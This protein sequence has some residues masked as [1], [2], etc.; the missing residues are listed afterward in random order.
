MFT[1]LARLVIYVE[2]KKVRRKERQAD[3]SE[4]RQENR[5]F[6]ICWR[7]NCFNLQ[8]L[9]REQSENK[10]LILPCLRNYGELFAN[11]TLQKKCTVMKI[12]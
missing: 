12:I 11:N 1:V 7:E 2:R 5:C 4:V 10:F 6:A 9:R 8:E 3:S